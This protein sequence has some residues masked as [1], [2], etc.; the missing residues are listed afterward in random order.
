MCLSSFHSEEKLNDHKTY[1][2]VHKA[3]KIEMP[4]PGENILQFEHYNRSLK[5]P[6]AVYADFE[7]MLQKT[8]TCQPSNEASY[9]NAYQK[10]TLVSFAYYIKYANGDFKAPV[11]YSGMDVAAVFYE[12]LKEDCLF[13]GKNFHDKVV[14]I[15]PLT[16]ADVYLLQKIITTRLSP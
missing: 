15:K 9:T 13:I 14:P 7:C 16:P 8:E 10:H 1:C 2:G 11:E 3:V 12:R 4:K 5:V 6:F